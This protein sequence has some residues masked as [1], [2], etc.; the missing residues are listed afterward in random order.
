[1]E[2]ST[3]GSVWLVLPT[4]NEAENLRA[5][6][7]SVKEH[8]PTDAKILIVDDSSPD[9]TGDFADQIAAA[10]SAIEVMHRPVKEGLGPAY[11]AGS[12]RR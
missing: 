10:N 5:A 9:G 4:Y 11:I 7:A 2:E 8:L 6:V 12:G 1:M 3:K